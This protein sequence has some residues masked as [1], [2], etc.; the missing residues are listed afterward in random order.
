MSE[1]IGIDSPDHNG[2]C[3]VGSK[4]GE[5]VRVKPAEKKRKLTFSEGVVKAALEDFKRRL[6][7]KP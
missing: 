4:E 2:S 6:G 5:P 7:L 1:E 3:R